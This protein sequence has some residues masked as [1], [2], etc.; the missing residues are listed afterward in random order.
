MMNEQIHKMKKHHHMLYIHFVEFF[1]IDILIEM[2]Y[3]ENHR[4]MNENNHVN[5]NKYYKYY[6]IDQHKKNLEYN[7]Q[8]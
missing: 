5:V 7:F 4:V 3:I 1:Y 8:I 2:I 6:L